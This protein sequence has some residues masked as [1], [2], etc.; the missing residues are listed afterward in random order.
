MLVRP[1]GTNLVITMMLMTMVQV[2]FYHLYHDMVRPEYS[3]TGCGVRGVG[4]GW[5]G[6]SG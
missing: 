2:L 3:S 4:V 5:V 6:P 1:Q